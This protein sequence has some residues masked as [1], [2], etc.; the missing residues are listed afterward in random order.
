MYKFFAAFHVYMFRVAMESA[1]C[2]QAHI[3]CVVLLSPVSLSLLERQERRKGDNNTVD[4]RI[5]ADFGRVKA[6]TAF[7]VFSVAGRPVASDSLDRV[8]G[9]NTVRISVLIAA[10]QLL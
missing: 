7:H 10:F 9:P 1:T 5:Q 8:K 4:G 2:L 6:L 3:Q